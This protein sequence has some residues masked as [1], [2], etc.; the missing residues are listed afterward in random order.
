MVYCSVDTYGDECLVE[1]QWCTSQVN[2]RVHS[3]YTRCFKSIEY[4]RTAISHSSAQSSIINHKKEDAKYKQNS[5]DQSKID[6]KSF[7]MYRGSSE[8]VNFSASLKILNLGH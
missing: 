2:D 3:T 6:Y 1:S 8:K 7:K 4:G 5:T